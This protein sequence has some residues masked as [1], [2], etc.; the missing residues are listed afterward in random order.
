MIRYLAAAIGLKAFSLNSATRSAYRRIGNT[1]GQKKRIKHPDI[2]IYVERGDLLVQLARKYSL[3]SKDISAVEVGTGW[4]H[5]YGLYLAL[6]AEKN[7]QLELF[8][9]WD[10][11]QLKALKNSFGELARYWE[12]SSDVSEQQ[13]NRIS[14]LLDAESFDEIY[15]QFNANYSLD[16]NGSLAS[17]PDEN[18]NLV[19]S[20]HVL[21][22]VG[23]E[24]I[25]DAIGHM[26][27]M[28]KPG[29][30]SVHQ[31][32]IDD[33]LAHYDKGV[34]E[35]NYL[36]YSLSLRKL[37]FENAV[38][39]HNALQVSDFLKCFERRNFE[40][41]EMEREKINIDDLSVHSDWKDYSQEDLET[42]IWTV[43]SRK[44][45]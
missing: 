36:T 19:F 17:Y 9:I 25:D 41:L 43:V 30:Y 20:F 11:R 38:Q 27:R 5:W 4:I 3:L 45:E 40:I 23:R 29:G 34:S 18:Y 33:H 12:R 15:K 42:T 16:E 7:V 6:H 39:Y 35:K 44:P 26:Y 28:L 2:P 8:D 37:I 13:R 31:V 24:N 14:S 1:L 21:E 32:G 10:N 22:H